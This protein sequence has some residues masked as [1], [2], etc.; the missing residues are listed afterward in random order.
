MDELLSIKVIFIFTMFVTAGVTGL[1]PIF[2][3]SFNNNHKLVSVGNCFAGGIFLLVG[4]A[5][6]LSDAQEAFDEVFVPSIPIGHVMAVVGYTMIM[7]IEKI[8][9]TGHSHNR[10]EVPKVPE[11]NQVSSDSNKLKSESCFEIINAPTKSTEVVYES[12]VPGLILST[13]LVVHSLF[14]GIAAGLVDSKSS[15]I[16]ICVAIVIHNII[17]AIALGIKLIGVKK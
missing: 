17:A 15:I 9:F 4:L 11:K 16:S 13:A 10:K 5:H 14:E 6:L 3:K 2:S 1:I 12:Y 7:F 8:I